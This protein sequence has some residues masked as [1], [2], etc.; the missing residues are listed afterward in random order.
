MAQF[1]T[2]VEI[3]QLA[4]LCSVLYQVNGNEV[5]VSSTGSV[6]VR[7]NEE[8][9]LLCKAA[10]PIKICN[11]VSP[12][13]VN[14]FVSKS[15]GVK[16]EDRISFLG[17]DETSDCGIKIEN[18]R[19]SDNGAW[20]CEVTAVTEDGTTK[21]GVD[22]VKLTVLKAPSRVTLEVDGMEAE[23]SL[24]LVYEKEAPKKIRC[25]ADGGQ[26]V[27]TFSW[28]LNGSPAQVSVQ[29][30]AIS[31]DG[32]AYEEV[33]FTGKPEDNTKDLECHVNSEAYTA[34]ELGEEQNVA[35]IM[36]NV[37][38]PPKALLEVHDFYGME[39][40]SS[41]PIRISFRLNPP[42]SDVQW[43]MHDGTMVPQ[44][45]ES[46]NGKYEADIPAEGPIQS[47]EEDPTL[48]TAIL[49]INQ[50][51][52]E[53]AGTLNKLH[54]TNAHGESVIRFKLGLGEKPA[55]DGGLGNQPQEQNARSTEAGSGP[56][57]AIVIIVLVIIVVIAVAVVARSQGLLCFSGRKKGPAEDQER[58]VEKEE[59]EGKEENGE[60]EE[61]DTE[62]AEHAESPIPESAADVTDQAT[63]KER[64]NMSQKMNH[65]LISL[66]NPFGSFKRPAPVVE[67]EELTENDG[68][69]KSDEAETENKDGIVYADLDKSVM[70]E[71]NATLTVENEKTEY[72]E[73]QQ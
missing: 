56:I 8:V 32:M 38:F 34:D 23:D 46:Q 59:K 40:G 70:S 13:G 48:Y 7:P 6:N 19:E 43:E 11:F 12:S 30:T 50:V 73:I 44:G 47:N 67:T 68:E 4:L 2:T 20:K 14:Y 64:R 57:I 41:Y 16:Y 69:E 36:L 58:A 45:S 60:K 33:L 42:P 62:S 53:D 51:A 66:K 5:S 37:E 15:L 72:V 24:T 27:P 9:D 18:V 63:Q 52:P 3:L 25:V 21:R 29:D 26:P 49:T 35:K 28:K 71:G 55:V 54:V 1:F 61:G 39:V 17:E 31:E 22:T 65:F 10:S